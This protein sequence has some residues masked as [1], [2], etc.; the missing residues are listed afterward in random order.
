VEVRVVIL[1][2]SEMPVTKYMR[3]RLNSVVGGANY[4]RMQGR[5]IRK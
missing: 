2:K 4:N 5:E 1:T 3:E